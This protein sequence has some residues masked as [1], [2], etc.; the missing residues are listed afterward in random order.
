MNEPDHA[1]VAV[2]GDLS[3]AQRLRAVVDPETLPLRPASR[4]NR[5]SSP[6]PLNHVGRGGPTPLERRAFGRQGWFEVDGVRLTRRQH[7]D[8][9]FR[10]QRAVLGGDDDWTVAVPIPDM[11]YRRTQPHAR[12]NCVRNRRAE[13]CD[14][15]ITP[16]RCAPRRA[17]ELRVCRLRASSGTCA[18]EQTDVCVREITAVCVVRIHWPPSW[19][20]QPVPSGASTV[21]ALQGTMSFEH[22][23]SCRG[24]PHA[25][26]GRRDGS[27]TST[28]A[29]APH[30]AG[31][32]DFDLR[33][34]FDDA[35][36]RNAKEI[37]GFRRILRH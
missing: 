12:T 22:H 18:I 29:P 34:Q 23:Q 27:A 14:P 5:C 19:L 24:R 25:D 1:N 28:F 21:I 30:R 33:T 17:F 11:R 26:R 3:H 2:G 16:K 7:R 10:S 8:D 35:V 32:S 31:V 36:G 37:R 4:Q 20:T 9:A 15:P 6:S 13:P